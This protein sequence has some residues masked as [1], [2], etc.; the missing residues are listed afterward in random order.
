MILNNH[1]GSHKLHSTTS[2]LASIH[3]KLIHNYYD[4]KYIAIIKTD[5]SASFDMVDHKILVQ[6][7]EFNDFKGDSF[8]IFKSFLSNRHKYVSIDGKESEIERYL[9]CSV[10]QGSKLFSLLYILYMKEIPLLY[11]TIGSEIYSKLKII[12]LTLT[13]IQFITISFSM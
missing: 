12:T 7:L 8:D 1:H 2:T 13:I 11:N 10:I 9:E 4:S 6:K 5:L 3:N